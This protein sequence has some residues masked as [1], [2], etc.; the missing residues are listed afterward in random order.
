MKCQ[1]RDVTEKCDV[2]TGKCPRSGCND[3]YGGVNCQT[4]ILCDKPQLRNGTAI[5]TSLKVGDSVRFRCIEGFVVY[6]KA[7]S[8]CIKER[9]G[10][11]GTWRDPAPTC[12]EITCESP[13]LPNGNVSLASLMFGETVDF[14]C[15]DGYV[16]E[17]NMNSTCISNGTG[18]P[19]GKW[20]DPTPSCIE[21]TCEEPTLLFGNVS[22]SSSTFGDTIDFMCSEGYVLEG[23]MNSTCIS[24][25]T[26]NPRGKW[27][28]PTPSCIE[29][30]CEEPTLLFGNVSSSSSTFGDTI[31]FICNDGYVLEGNMNS[32]CISNGTGN[33]RGKWTDPTPSC[34]EITCEEP[35]LLF[36]NVSSSSSTFGDTIDFICNDGYV[37]EGNMN[38]TCIS[39]GTGNP[40]GKWTD[41]TPSC[42]EITCEE[43]TLLFGNV[44][45]SSSTF[46]DTIDF[47]CSEGY[48]L[49][50]N[51][52][53]TC[54]S[55]GTG[56]P[57]GKWTDP[58]PSCIEITCEE[59]TL[60]FGNVSSS[61]STFGDTID[62]MCS[63]GYVLKGN[64][65]STCISNGTGNPRGKW[66]DPTPSCIEITCEEPTLLFGNVSSSSSTFGDTID[67]MCSEG[68][69]LKGNMN[70]TC[71]SNGTGN[72]RGKWTDPTPSCIEITC[73]EPTLLFGNVSQSPSTFGDTIDFTC[74]EG[75]VLK[76]NMNSTCISNGT[77]NPRGKWTDPT[78]SCIEITCEE[79]T[80]LFGNVSQ[81]PSTFG[82]TIDFT[83]S[84]GYGLKGN[85]NSTC[86]SN[87]TGN[88]RGKWSNMAPSC[89][90]KK[91]TELPLF[92][93]FPIHV[94]A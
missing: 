20:T 64:M 15:N 47:M 76:G 6:G 84:E 72:P 88:P 9:T 53:S 48:V 14:I 43:P 57:R 27:T 68:Y 87:G 65:N 63:E 58:T 38:S 2:I 22:S 50:G 86:I 60:L 12:T 17:G 92:P 35:T 45:S 21:I 82:D 93:S 77:G 55:N 39:N 91:Q 28:D 41:P 26:G 62:F 70:S 78:P 79:P 16:L 40:R 24:N 31:D 25:G 29:I 85:M 52:N 23:N 49:E 89:V 10:I 59:P 66:T 3:K 46:G 4:E 32:T 74:S 19:R 8:T 36:G 7:S 69:V 44:S 83:C 13:R 94:P 5:T 73:E 51:M 33:P 11:K 71:I 75:Y 34:I 30:T 37:L 61:S 42:I 80:L 1:C 81:S 18:N 54:I 56:N 90:G 67:F